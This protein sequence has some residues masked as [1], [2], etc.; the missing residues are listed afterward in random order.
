MFCR[1]CGAP[2]AEGA[3]FCKKCGT[4]VLTESEP[5]LSGRQTDRGIW[6]ENG[7]NPNDPQDSGK[8]SRGDRKDPGK[9]TKKERKGFSG[10]QIAACVILLLLTVAC[11]VG[12]LVT[13]KR[14]ADPE[15]AA[16][17]YLEALLTGD[18]GAAY[19]MLDF[20]DVSGELLEFLTPEVFARTMPAQES[21]DA[22][23]TGDVKWMKTSEIRNRMGGNAEDEDHRFYTLTWKEK[24]SREPGEVS[25][26][27]VRQEEKKWG[28]FP[29]WKVDAKALQFEPI[30]LSA[31]QG[32][33]LTIDGHPLLEDWFYQTNGNGIN[34]YQVRL[35]NTSY[36]LEASRPGFEPFSAVLSP[37][38]KVEVQM[39]TLT[40]DCKKELLNRSAE[41]LR[42]TLTAASAGTE[43]QAVEEIDANGGENY[44]ADLSQMQQMFNSG[45]GG[46]IQ[47]MAISDLKG[48]VVLLNQGDSSYA[49]VKLSGKMAYRFISRYHNYYTGETTYPSQ[50]C[51]ED[52][53]ASFQYRYQDDGWKLV[54][55]SF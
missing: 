23:L 12:T 50:D 21:I 30:L 5:D 18:V 42:E 44:R 2:L 41:Y 29:V 52:L 34:E 26:M 17:R 47:D 19:G 13:V 14:L 24:G 32:V 35:W 4:P 16:R 1:K 27:L 40:E 53:P 3:R 8:K 39:N 25:V 22:G 15:R 36:K 11:I 6:P 55:M 7:G 33:A 46:G 31:P 43:S 49:E 54:D 9:K 51:S 45:D 38:K 10:K 20:S 28:I 37:E 48:T